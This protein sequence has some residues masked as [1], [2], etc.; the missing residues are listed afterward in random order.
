MVDDEAGDEENEEPAADE[1]EDEP[2]ECG[3][4]LGMR[5]K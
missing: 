2:C 4:V 5:G 1:V 3:E